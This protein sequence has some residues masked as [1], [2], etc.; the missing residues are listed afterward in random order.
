[1][2]FGI[3]TGEALGDITGQ[4]NSSANRNAFSRELNVGDFDSFGG[5]V[6]DGKY[7]EI[8]R[9][10]V[11]AD[12]EWSWGYGSAKNPENQGYLY[13]DLMDNS[14]TPVAVDGQLR[15]VI[16]SSTG[17][18][19]EVVKDIDTERLDQSKTNRQ[20]MVPFPEQV[21]SSLATQ[22]AY[23]V[24]KLDPVSSNDGDT[25]SGANSDVIIPASEY[26]LS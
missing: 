26:D 24:G 1:M 5:S 25:V 22:D 15:F 14:S 2:P 12:T 3:D 17:R 7:V 23:L 4:P 13:V 19:T 20:Q 21:Q 16:E 6:T 18:N 11:P 9:L 10:Q 8:F